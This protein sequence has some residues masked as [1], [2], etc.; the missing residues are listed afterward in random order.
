MRH[1]LGAAC[2]ALV[3][4]AV[5]AQ[6]ITQ[7]EIRAAV[8]AIDTDAI[9]AND[10]HDRNW[11]NY[12]LNYAETRYSQLDAITTDNVGEL[13]LEWSYNLNSDR[14][15]QSTPIVVDGVM[16]V[17]ASWS[18]VHALDAV[19]GE[20]LWVY[21][22]EVPG[23]F[24]ERGCCD[25]V[26]RGVAVYD[27]MVFVGAFDGYLHAIDA[28][29]GER[30][31]VTDTIENREMS[32]TITGAPRVINGNVL[33]GN[34]GAEFGVRGYISAFDAATGEMSWRWYVVPGDPTLPYENA[35]MEMAAETWDPSAEYWLA[36]GGGTIWD[37]MAYDPDLNLLYVGTGNGSPWNQHLRSPAGGDNLFLASIVALNPDT[38]E[39]VWH[40]QN[41]PGDTW[42]YTSTQHIILA[43]LEIDGEM[44]QILM[45]AP[46]N[47]FFYVIDRA[48]GE[49]ISAEPFV[50]TTWAT[51]YD[52]N[53][54]P[55]ENPAARSRDE[56]FETVPSAY[57]AHNWHPMSY[58]PDTGL[59]YIP[60][61][62]VP[63]VQ[64]TDPNWALNS[65]QPMSTMSGVGWNLGYLFNVV[66][67][68]A[69]PFGHLLAWDPVAQHEVWRAEYVSPW[70]G[71]T[72]TTAGNLVFQGTADGR[73]IAY[74]ATTGEALWQVPV[75]SGVVAA[76]N[77]WEHD[78]QQYVTIAVGWGG[79]Y[80]LMQRATDRVGAG[81]VFT[82]RVGANQPMP[83]AE[84]SSRLELVSGV[85]YD[86]DHVGEGLA[87]YVSNCLFCH[88]VPGVNN[89]GAIPNLG[90]STPDVLM[91][92][93]AW[94]LDGI[95]VDNGMPSFAER[96][97]EEDVTRL[98]AFIQGTADAVR[99][100]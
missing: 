24:G 66:A 20:Q 34:G 9:I 62:G 84:L 95:G 8:G 51:A 6:T 81:R 99:P 37:A 3:A 63:L 73:F 76:P 78:G 39:Y 90:Y 44:R 94:I 58:N 77:T 21:D 56:P 49:F 13:G 53:G 75:T 91:N 47:G 80:G 86:P 100:Q 11:L 82:F 79:V 40:Y 2:A 18:I 16:Y 87:I 88:G 68:E 4:G 72:L 96:L 43:D 69:T 35:A 23:D 57:G 42:D 38:G 19:T 27:G 85:P 12:G 52:E 22:P 89:G 31:W 45:Q 60:A 41:T 61:Q 17:T 48:N 92:A 28:A 55:I 36:G 15:V 59:V 54:R 5:Q 93:N 70:N 7:D 64:S 25:V 50:E 30:V 98:V 67:P 14:G 26:N 97:S 29:T 74:D 46:K 71:G 83:E 1:L 33:I 32:Y 65:H 10:A